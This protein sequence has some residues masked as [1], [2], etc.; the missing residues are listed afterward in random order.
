MSKLGMGLFYTRDDSGNEI[1]RKG[2]TYNKC[3]NLYDN[4]HKELEDKVTK[5]IE[6]TGNCYIIDCHSFHD[7]MKYTGYDVD[8]FPDVCL[9]FNGVVPSDEIIWIKKLFEKNGYV[10]EYNVPFAGSI[11]PLQ[12]LNDKR[13]KSVMI[14]LN[15]R[16]YCG[17]IEEFKKVQLLCKMIYDIF[18]EKN[19]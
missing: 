5:G 2:L 15:R 10:V 1:R 17:S 13:V 16:I 7:N 8:G 11:V 14:E 9:G 3:I 12:Y 19:K 6:K 4:Y 18:V